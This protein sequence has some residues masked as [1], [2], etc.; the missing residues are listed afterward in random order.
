MAMRADNPPAQFHGFA[1]ADCL[2]VASLLIFAA[3]IF[4]VFDGQV[5][6]WTKSTSKFGMEMEERFYEMYRSALEETAV[7]SLAVPAYEFLMTEEN[8][9]FRLLQEAYSY[10]DSNEV[11]W[12]DWQKP[13]FEG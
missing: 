11:W 13:M 2:Y 10:L 12:D 8:R 1:T 4:D 6:R 9:H 5:A 3:M 7:D